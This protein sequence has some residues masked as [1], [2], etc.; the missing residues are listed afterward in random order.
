MKPMP[1]A[2]CVPLCG[3]KAVRKGRCLAHQ[4]RRTVAVRTPAGAKAH[5]LYN[6]KRW[7]DRSKA[8]L[9]KEP[10]CAQCGRA[11]EHADHVIPHQGDANLFCT[12]ELQTLCAS[13]HG[14]KSAAES[15]ALR[16]A[17]KGFHAQVEHFHR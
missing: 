15:N 14:R 13:C 3:R 5:K 11:G 2:C 1:Y 9:A 10:L 6:N 12:G 4:K 16:D 8:Q 7:R 17:A